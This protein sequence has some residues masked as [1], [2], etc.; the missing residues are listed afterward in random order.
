[1]DKKI[2]TVKVL[3]ID[4]DGN[5]VHELVL[6]NKGELTIE[7]DTLIAEEPI[8]FDWTDFKVTGRRVTITEE[9]DEVE[10]H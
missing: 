8:E 5:M 4:E 6:G 9:Y 1:M 10:I 3:L 2:T 7:L